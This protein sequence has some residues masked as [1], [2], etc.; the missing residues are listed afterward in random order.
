MRDDSDGCNVRMFVR[1]FNLKCR[2][3]HLEKGLFEFIDEEDD[4]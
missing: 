4:D 3:Q 1:E 2:L